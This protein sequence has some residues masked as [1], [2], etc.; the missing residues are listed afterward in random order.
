[1]NRKAELH[2]V[3]RIFKSIDMKVDLSMFSELKAAL[4][5]K[6]DKFDIAGM[7]MAR[8]NTFE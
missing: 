5:A 4:E 7:G 6:A 1:M 2:D 8:G 3:D